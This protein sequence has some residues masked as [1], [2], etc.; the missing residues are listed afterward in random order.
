MAYLMC[1]VVIYMKSYDDIKK[2]LHED[3]VRQN[4]RRITN[5]FI[6]MSI[7][8]FIMIGIAIGVDMELFIRNQYLIGVYYIDNCNTNSNTIG[9]INYSNIGLG[10]NKTCSEVCVINTSINGIYK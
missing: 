3:Y 7:I 9:H 10:S 1:I 5:G 2:I 4:G 8:F 6:L